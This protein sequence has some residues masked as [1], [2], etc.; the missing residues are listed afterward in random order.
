MGRLVDCC[1]RGGDIWVREVFRTEL[2]RGIGLT[3][4]SL[5]DYAGTFDRHLGPELAEHVSRRR[6]ALRREDDS[7]LVGIMLATLSSNQFH[8]T[9]SRDTLS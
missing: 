3:E 5:E 4:D 7:F 9:T 8:T 6:P 2:G 1:S